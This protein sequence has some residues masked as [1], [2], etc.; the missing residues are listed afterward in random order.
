MYHIIKVYKD[1]SPRKSIQQNLI[2]REHRTEKGSFEKRVFRV[3]II[4]INDI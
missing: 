1:Y 2:N 3:S 4:G